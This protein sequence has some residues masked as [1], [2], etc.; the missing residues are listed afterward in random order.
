MALR[1]AKRTMMGT[2]HRL[3]T[4]D[5]NYYD[6]FTKQMKAIDQVRKYDAVFV[7]YVHFSKAFGAFS[8]TAYRILD[9]HDTFAH[10]F[11]PAQV[12]AGLRRAHCAVAIQDVEA[13]ILQELLGPDADRVHM[14]SHILDVSERGAGGQHSG[15]N[16]CRLLT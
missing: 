14:L 10:E 11:A 15:C 9:T 4:I 13:V 5:E 7:E 3:T 12:A 1:R 8:P 6:P 16:L 2:V